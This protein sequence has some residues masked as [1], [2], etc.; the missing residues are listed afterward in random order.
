MSDPTAGIRTVI[1]RL[2]PFE[3]L[4]TGRR[5]LALTTLAHLAQ[6]LGQA[7]AWH[8]I[9][10]RAA[11]GE[12]TDIGVDLEA[13][14]TQ[15][16]GRI[17]ALRAVFTDGLIA[18]ARHAGAALPHLVRVAGSLAEDQRT[19]APS[20]FAALFEAGLAEMS[21]GAVSGALA[22]SSSLV[23]LLVD[24]LELDSS[25]SVLDPRCGLGTTLAHV[26]RRH[27]DVALVGQEVNVLLAA[28]TRLRLH[29]LGALCEIRIGNALSPTTPAFSPRM[30]DRV[31]CHPPVGARIPKEHQEQL[32]SRHG[33]QA[34]ALRSETLF[35]LH[36][37]EAVAAH[38]R[39]VVLMPIST[40]R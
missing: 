16:E 28:L 1:S 20:T 37:L 8:A 40:L 14:A 31:V 35:L 33:L 10:D 21:Q 26:A 7:G 3:R 24:L 22:P 30:F 19:A 5:V 12:A 39:A 13:L 36:C 32:A 11:H 9:R 23:R 38:G 25:M 15:M 27:P 6:Q 34:R 4:D 2:R 17:P 18:D 29:L